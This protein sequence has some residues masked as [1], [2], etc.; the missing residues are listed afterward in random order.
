[1]SGK[2]TWTKERC[3]DLNKLRKLLVKV[4][5]LNHSPNIIENISECVKLANE[6][7]K[8]DSVSRCKSFFQ[9]IEEEAIKDRQNNIG[10]VRKEVAQ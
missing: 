9:F 3:G 5:L 10:E 4:S 6:L 2:M 7:S 8:S 1:M